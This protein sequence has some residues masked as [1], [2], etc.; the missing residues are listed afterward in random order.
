[1]HVLRLAGT[2]AYMSWAITL[3]SGSVNGLDGITAA[4]EPKTISKQFLTDAVRLWREFLWPHARAA[5]RQIG[6]TDR[7]KYARRV[8]RWIAHHK[9]R[10]VSRDEVREQ[11]LT[12]HLDAE[13]TQDVL[14]SLE[15]AG[16]LKCDRIKTRGRSKLRWRVNP[17][18]FVTD[19]VLET[20]ETP[21]SG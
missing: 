20:P 7:H 11:A 1:M 8:L 13:G 6:L 14:E 2:L 3:G 9:K 19:G 5:M 15:K 16:W 18:L 4:L 17:K 21:E 10:E 12:R